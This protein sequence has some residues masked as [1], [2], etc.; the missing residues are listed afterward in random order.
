MVDVDDVV[1]KTGHCSR[2]NSAAD[3]MVR[4]FI[5]LRVRLA[6]SVTK[7]VRIEPSRCHTI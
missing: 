2:E 1:V 6:R 4:V 5:F 7:V 3:P